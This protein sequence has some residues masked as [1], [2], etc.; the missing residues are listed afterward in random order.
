M[1]GASD[2]SAAET[3]GVELELKAVLVLPVPNV[4]VI[5]PKENEGFA[6]AV[7]DASVKVDF[8]VADVAAAIGVSAKE[9]P[10]D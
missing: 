2:V 7:A 6:G 9:K 5:G 10:W 8:D 3:C 1:L 4:V